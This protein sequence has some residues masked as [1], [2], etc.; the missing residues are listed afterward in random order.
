MTF[1]FL[2]LREQEHASGLYYTGFFNK[3]T[4]LPIQIDTR[5]HAAAGLA[6]MSCI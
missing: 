2:E 3:S 6:K 5:E 4:Q 1:V